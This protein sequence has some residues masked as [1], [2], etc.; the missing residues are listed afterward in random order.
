MLNGIEDTLSANDDHINLNQLGQRIILP[1]SYIGGPCDM[2]QCYLDGMAIACHFKKIDIFLTMTA[3][4]N[5]TRIITWSSRSRSS[6]FGVACLST[7]EKGTYECCLE[8]RNLWS[9]SSSCLCNRVS[10]M[11]FTS[12][13]FATVSQTRL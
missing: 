7:E 13:A 11:R 4:P 9:L 12:Y 6:R 2:H 8:R 3:N 10:E 5:Q 1:F